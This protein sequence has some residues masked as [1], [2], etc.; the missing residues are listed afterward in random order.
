MSFKRWT[1]TRRMVQ[2]TVIC[3][4]ASP[5]AGLTIF[6]GTLAAGELFGLPLA[7]PL[8]ALQV[9]LATGVIVP[10][11]MVSASGVTLF[12]F[13]LGGRTFCGWVCPVYLV[14]ELADTLRKRLGSAEQTVPLTTKSWV[15]A[16]TCGLTAITGLPLFEILSPIGMT[17]RAIAF[18]SWAALLCVGGILVLETMLARRIWC[19]SICPL[20]GFYALVG[21]YA[22]LKVAFNNSR[23][24]R[25]GECSLVCPVEEVLEPSL[26]RGGAQISSGECT[27][28]G[29]CIDVCSSSAL[30][31]GLRSVPGRNQDAA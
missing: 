29:A 26:L 6:Q 8:A 24:N 22:P 28:C 31:F 30:T 11:F 13:L 25:C 2:V 9:F 18:G 17:G 20:G 15:L 23:C 14:T 27:R 1:I 19:R 3:L 4:I 7:D 16:A 12:Y 10:A 5:L 21:R